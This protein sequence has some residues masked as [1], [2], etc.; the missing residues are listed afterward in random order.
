[1]AADSRRTQA[2]LHRET[3]EKGEAAALR[4][5]AVK[6]AAIRYSSGT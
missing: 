5:A 4:G 1:M 2:N 6:P 3:R